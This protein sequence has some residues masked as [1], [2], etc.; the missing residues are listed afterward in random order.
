MKKLWH[1]WN[2]ARSS[3]ASGLHHCNIGTTGIYYQSFLFSPV[4]LVLGCITRRI[5]KWRK[6]KEESAHSAEHEKHNFGFPWTWLKPFS[7]LYSINEVECY[8]IFGL[9]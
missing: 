1:R 6:F 7:Q 3:F 4:N 5:L 2:Q 9:I 8:S